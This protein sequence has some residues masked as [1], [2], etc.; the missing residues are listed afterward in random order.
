MFYTR[1]GYTILRRGLTVLR[2]CCERFVAPETLFFVA[3]WVAFQV[4]FR[5]RAFS[6]PGTLWHTVVGDSILRDGFMT[7]DPFTYTHP[8]RTWI[9]Q[10]WGGEVVMTLLHRVGGFD[11]LLLAFSTGI[12]ALFTWLF[13][14]L[15]RAGLHWSLAA[16]VACGAL[17]VASFH[18]Y[19]RPHLATMV[20]LAV[21]MAILVDFDRG[22]VSLGRLALLIPL[23]VVWT[24]VHGGVLG[25]V[26]SFG[27]VAAGWAGSYLVG[28]PGPIASVRTGF[29]VLGVLCSCALT[30]FDNPF[31]MEMIHTW[32][33]IVGS[34]VMAQVVNEH[35][36]LGLSSPLD[37]MLLVFALLYCVLLAGTLP[38]LRTEFR[39]TWLVPLVWMV[40]MFK[41]IRQGP[42]FVMTATVVVADFWPHTRW[43][44]WLKK[45]GDSLAYGTVTPL[46]S[47]AFAVPTAL[48]LI[49]FG[50]QAAGV[51]VPVFGRGWASFSRDFVPTDLTDAIARELDTAPGRPRLFNDC[52]LGGYL[53]YYH[54]AHKIFMDDRFE[55]YGDPWLADYV[56]AAEKHPERI[57]DYCDKYA[58]THALV[59]VE[60]TRTPFDAYLS[61][62]PR[63]HEV[64]RGQ[65]AVLFRRV[66]LSTP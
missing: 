7:T 62:S 63:W 40:L 28:R 58:C 9:P 52:N 64:A 59:G 57:E 43:H 30:P 11:A 61:N 20:C 22:R 16:V 32:Q 55:L 47:S 36:P 27:L 1:A 8:G 5:E 12:A 6:D 53:I 65:G 24:N 42:L 23:F 48:V 31:G 21:T 56:E 3:V 35:K 60:L 2:K 19:I 29:G 10:Q 33:R 15:R 14:R 25:G 38:K 37:Q 39:F 66:S 50:M 46:R 4:H 54:P 18:F 26:L 17:F 13:A 49:A 44:D 51:S 45:Y 34:T 41:G